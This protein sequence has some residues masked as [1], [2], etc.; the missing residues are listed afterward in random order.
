MTLAWRVDHLPDGFRRDIGLRPAD[1]PGQL[2]GEQWLK[3]LPEIVASRL[4]EWD[5]TIDG[6]AVTGLSAVVIPVRQGGRRLSLKVSWPHAEARFEHLALRAWAGGAAVG[7]V[8]AAPSDFALLLERCD[9]ADQV[10]AMN[11]LDSAELVGEL[12]RELVHPALPQLDTASAW[13]GRIGERLR[14]PNLPLPRRFIEQG[15]ALTRDLAK[16]ERV[17]AELIHTDL[18]DGNIMGAP[19]R[20]AGP[21]LV[22]IDP[23]PISGERA[24]ALAPL[25]WNR[26]DEAAGAYNLRNHLRF[27]I[28]YAAEPAGVDDARARSWTIVRLLNNA[29]WELQ[30]DPKSDLTKTVAMVKAMQG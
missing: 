20:G 8:A 3:A 18:H 30:R 5:L 19:R 14:K 16:D 25:V 21:R 7:L 29:W 22:A 27:R 12:L 2:S 26:W 24:M 6:P 10:A 28:D 23:K 11:A 13:L 15:L 1:S 9:P 17:D 4:D